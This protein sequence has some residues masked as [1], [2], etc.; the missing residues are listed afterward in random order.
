MKLHRRE[1]LTAGL[2]GGAAAAALPLCSFGQPD[3]EN[4]NYARLDTVLAQPTFKKELFADPVI[5]ESVELLRYG[6]SFLCR[7]R[8]RDGAEGISVAHDTMRLLYPI[9]VQRI[10]PF[11]INQDARRLDELVEKALVFAFNFRLGGLGIGIPLATIEFAILDMM[12]RISGKSVGQLI[13]EIHNT[14]IPVYQATE[15]REKSVKESVALIQAAVEESKAQAVKIKV[16]ALMFMTKDLDAKGPA[17]RTEAIIPLIRETFGDDMA[18]YA[19]ANG[20]YKDVNE[21]IRVGKLL[22]EYNYSYFEE[23]VFFDWLDGTKHV[24]DA[25]AIPVAGGEQQ[26]GIHAFRWLL[27]NDGL[28]IVQP[29][30][31]YFGGM[32]R[33]LKVARM[34][35]VMGKKCIPHLSGGFGFIYMLHLVSAMPNAGPHIEFKGYTDLPIECKT[36]SLRLEDGKIKVPT[37]PGIGVDIDPDYIKKYSVVKDV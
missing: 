3:A 23:P 27:A 22:Q 33:S 13:G 12:G 21:A 20:Y 37:G 32:I 4:P 5:I 15:W 17:G 36:S 7:V 14:H 18:L 19:D 35:E 9:F 28:D 25:L 24:A 34:G 29:D 16:G 8:S 30:H 31:Y 1:L 26:H 6:G 2:A 11:F 10:Q